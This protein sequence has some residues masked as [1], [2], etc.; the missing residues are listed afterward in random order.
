MGLPN[1]DLLLE[2]VLGF[3]SVG[4]IESSDVYRAQD[5]P[6]IESKEHSLEHSVQMFAQAMA[7]KPDVK[8][9]KLTKKA[10]QAMELAEA[11]V[12][13][14]HTEQHTNAVLCCIGGAAA[15]FYFA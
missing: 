11:L 6:V 10:S 4:L 5:T 7:E 13:R 1:V 15:K 12:G 8:N 2:F 3:R 9:A 14:A